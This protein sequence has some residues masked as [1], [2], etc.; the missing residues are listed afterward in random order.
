LMG[1]QH[2][3]CIFLLAYSLANDFNKPKHGVFNSSVMSQSFRR[4]A[5]NIA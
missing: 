5:Q 2:L 3:P 1:I 4:N